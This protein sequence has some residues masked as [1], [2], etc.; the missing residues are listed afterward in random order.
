M[1]AS[2]G[3]ARP[4]QES[5][6]EPGPEP[7]RVDER[8]PAD[9]VRPWHT[10]MSGR[11]P[12]EEHRAST[13]LELLFDLC[14]VVAVAQAGAAL[15]HDLAEG[16]IGHGL[17]SYLIVFFTIWWPWVNFTWFASAYDTDDVLYRL[18]T[19][20]QIAGVLVVAAGVPRIF[21]DL[22]FS[23]GVI[24]YV[25]MRAALV[26]QWLRVAR[27]DPLGR[28]AALRFATGIGLVQLLWVVRLAVAGPVGLVL[29][30][31]FGAL[32]LLIPVW[33]ERAGR[34]TPWN[35]EH[36]AERYGLFT[37]IV[38]GEC[39]LAATTAVQVALAASGVSAA[40]LAVAVGGLVLVF[41][42]WWAY[43]KVPAAI[44][45][46]LALRWQ[47][48]WGY[49]HYVIFAAIAALGAGLQVAG[50]AV[51]DPRRLPSV[52]AA[53]TVAIPVAVYLVAVGLL[54]RRG[55]A[56]SSLAPVSV[57]S[58]LV[59]AA[60]VAAGFLG[61]PIAVL[62]MSILASGTVAVNVILFQRRAAAA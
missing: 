4:R 52:T 56:W 17:A 9:G 31:V 11:D 47:I 35:R 48:A 26:A 49:G 59:I 54:H 45:H 41:A 50:D 62:A 34:Q 44:G 30:F 39:V 58:L 8:R 61:V 38:L 12:L 27:E 40:L 28:P 16:Q 1:D 7:E 36:I 46:H 25:I 6:P 43:F 53:M 37:I 22:D 23:I 55:N 60:A 15:H 32:E 21:T 3:V 33:A 42:M 57:T 14:F 24:G 19:F 10:P 51:T 20:V 13:P 29:I 2:T 5:Q 18:L